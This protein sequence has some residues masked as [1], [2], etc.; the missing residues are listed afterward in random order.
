MAGEGGGAEFGA[1]IAFHNRLVR[2]AVGIDFEEI[3]VVTSEQGAD[4]GEAFSERLVGGSLSVH[5]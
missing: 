1:D 3:A 4:L 2:S 5:R